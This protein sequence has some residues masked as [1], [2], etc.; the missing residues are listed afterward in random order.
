MVGD[1]ERTAQEIVE[2]LEAGSEE[3]IPTWNGKV[4]KAANRLAPAWLARSSRVLTAKNWKEFLGL[5]PVSRR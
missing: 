4:M 3:I 2:G 1:V 5:K